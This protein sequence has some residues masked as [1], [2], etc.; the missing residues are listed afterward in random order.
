MLCVRLSDEVK[1]ALQLAAKDDRRT[2]SNLL[3]VILIEGL[4]KRGYLDQKGA[5]K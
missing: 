2:M 3:E 1:D 4:S 5:R